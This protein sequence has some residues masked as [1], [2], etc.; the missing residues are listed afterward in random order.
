MDDRSTLVRRLSLAAVVLAQS[1]AGSLAGLFL[2]FGGGMAFVL[3]PV[4]V[5]LGVWWVGLQ[6]PSTGGFPRRRRPRVRLVSTAVGGALGGGAAA[7]LSNADLALPLIVLPLLG[8]LL[9]F[10]GGP[11]ARGGPPAIRRPSE[12]LAPPAPFSAAEPTPTRAPALP[13]E[14]RSDGPPAG[15]PSVPRPVAPRYEQ[16][17]VAIA[18]VVTLSVLLALV[19]VAAFTPSGWAQASGFAIPVLFVVA[20]IAVAVVKKTRQRSIWMGVLMGYGV[21]SIIGVGVC[22]VVLSSGAGF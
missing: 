4:G 20:F 13:G 7:L 21:A 1:A 14:S 18:A 12:L 15:P 2:G 3:A 17:V 22:S 19:T 10:H 16:N 11:G 5:V 8:A 9:G 6:A